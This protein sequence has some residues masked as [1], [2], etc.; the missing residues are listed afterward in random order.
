MAPLLFMDRG[1]KAD[2]YPWLIWKVRFFVIGAGL[3][4]GGMILEMDWLI[5][6][7]IVFLAAGF[8]IRFLPGGTGVVEGEPEEGDEELDEEGFGESSPQRSR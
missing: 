2:R 8:L 5:F 7:A 1:R 3:A 4:V 6:V